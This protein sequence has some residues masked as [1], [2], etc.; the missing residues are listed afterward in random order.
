[1]DG[2]LGITADVGEDLVVTHFDESEFDPVGV[3][4]KVFKGVK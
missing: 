1:L 2:D 4:T 3:G